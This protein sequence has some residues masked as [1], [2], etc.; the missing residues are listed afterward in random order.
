[1]LRLDV[2]SLFPGMFAGPFNESIVRRAQ[3]RGIVAIALHDIRQWARDRHR[4]TDD[5]PY[6][7]GAGM[8]MLAP[9]IIDAVEDVLGDDLGA[10]RIVIMSAAGK[11]FTQTM[12]QDLARSSRIALICGRY[13]GIDDRAT[14]I[15]NAEEVSIGDYVLTGGELAA[16]VVVDAV[17]RLLP[18]VIDAASTAEESHQDDLVEYPHFTR[19]QIYREYEVPAVLL[20]GH[21]AEIA[22]WRREQSLRRTARLR[23]ELIDLDRLTE[24]ERAIVDQEIAGDDG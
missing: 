5:T 12:A 14:Q 13:E 7:G 8:V 2:F 24:T 21:H 19:P 3:D 4:T 16:M 20:S 22:R 11:R 6:G 23:P 17:T 10:A 18:G 1:M 15:L 9:P